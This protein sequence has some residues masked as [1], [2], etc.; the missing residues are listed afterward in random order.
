MTSD[1]RIEPIGSDPPVDGVPDIIVDA[2]GLLCP[3][4]LVK[5]ARAIGALAPGTLLELQCDD[6]AALADVPAWCEARRHDY[7]GVCREGSVLR[8]FFRKG[9]AAD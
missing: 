7:L 9:G 4:P 6:P 8:F 3:L 5:V 2:M 1:D